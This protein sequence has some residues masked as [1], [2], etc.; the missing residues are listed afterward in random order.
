MKTVCAGKDHVGQGEKKR[1][2]SE[3]I[4][5]DR[6]VFRHGAC[7]HAHIIHVQTSFA[8]SVHQLQPS[9]GGCRTNSRHFIERHFVKSRLHLGRRN[10]KVASFTR[11]P[12]VFCLFFCLNAADGSVCCTQGQIRNHCA[13]AQPVGPSP[14]W[15]FTIFCL[16]CPGSLRRL[17]HLPGQ[18]Q[19]AFYKRGQ[20]AEQSRKK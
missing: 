15:F 5:E 8:R 1:S 4:K 12:N 7:M 17:Q 6:K 9:P 16:S 19:Q 11:G 20:T 14:N 3:A 10:I 2:P 13:L 18:L